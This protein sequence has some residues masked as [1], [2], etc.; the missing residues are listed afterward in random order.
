[1]KTETMINPHFYSTENRKHDHDNVNSKIEDQAKFGK[2]EQ[3]RKP[4]DYSGATKLFD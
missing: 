4:K 3:D 1:M 2:P